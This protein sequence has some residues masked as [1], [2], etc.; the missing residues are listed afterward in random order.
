[1]EKRKRKK[2]SR[3]LSNYLPLILEILPQLKIKKTH[4]NKETKKRKFS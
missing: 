3:T 2:Y 4:K 1:M